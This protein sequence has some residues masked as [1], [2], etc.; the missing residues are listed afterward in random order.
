V[1]N[2]EA[3]SRRVLATTLDLIR[4][5]GMIRIRRE[6]L[7]DQAQRSRKEF[8]ARMVRQLERVY[9][10]VLWPLSPNERSEFVSR[11]VSFALSFGVRGEESVSRLL[12]YVCMCGEDLKGSPF[13]TWMFEVLS[14]PDLSEEEKLAELDEGMYGVDARP[15]DDTE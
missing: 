4:R 13:R 5:R 8:E 11:S 14:D 12:E 9:P 7:D 6:Q 10:E 2:G 1:G 3:G 15:G